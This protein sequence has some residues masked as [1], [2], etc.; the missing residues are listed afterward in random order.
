MHTR[1]HTH[2]V[3]NVM[4]I[5]NTHRNVAIR[6][7]VSRHRLPFTHVMSPHSLP[8]HD[9]EFGRT[10]PTIDTIEK[11]TQRGEDEHNCPLPFHHDRDRDPGQV[12]RLLVF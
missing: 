5:L 1:T 6:L 10:A 12:R 11:L 2:D 8:I 4:A 9:H 7:S 3:Y